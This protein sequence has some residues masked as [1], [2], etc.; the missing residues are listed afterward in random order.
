VRLKALLW[1]H[2]LIFR[3]WYIL[4]IYSVIRSW[5]I[6][7]IVIYDANLFIFFSATTDY[8]V[9]IFNLS[10]RLPTN[11]EGVIHSEKC[12]M[13]EADCLYFIQPDYLWEVI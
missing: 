11:E 1:A 4:L 2:N 13:R 3:S 12:L 6:W 10:W 9:F 8:E 7:Y 5:H